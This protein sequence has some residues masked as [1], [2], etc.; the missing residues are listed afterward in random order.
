M[1]IK[2]SSNLPSPR[3]L[4]VPEVGK[5]C[6]VSRNTVYNWVKKG[7]L[8]AYQTPGRTNLIRPGDLILFMRESGMFIP[9][10]L[11]SIA[12]DDANEVGFVP[13]SELVPKADLTTVLF[14]SQEEK[15][16]SL[17]ERAL[18][19]VAKVLDARTGYEALHVLTVHDEVRMV[20][21]CANLPGLSAPETVAQIEKIRPGLPVVMIEESGV[22]PAPPHGAVRETLVKP[23]RLSM[24]RNAFASLLDL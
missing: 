23:L 2:Q 4:T 13:K 1:K 15:E 3:F 8:D 17:G 22:E 6:G 18:S 12:T 5:I 10:Q 16:L 19:D 20:Y 24:I 9:E 11:T 21:L 14:V 7:V